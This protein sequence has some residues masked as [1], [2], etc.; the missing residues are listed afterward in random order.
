MAVRNKAAERVAKAR[1]I[2]HDLEEPGDGLS[3][4]SGT[5]WTVVFNRRG[6]VNVVARGR[7]AF[8]VKRLERIIACG[9]PPA[10]GGWWG[11]I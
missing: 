9:S 6:P 3:G 8:H 2:H 7:M 5:A 4:G 10:E 1:K 11:W